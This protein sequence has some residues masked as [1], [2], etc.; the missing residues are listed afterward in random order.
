MGERKYILHKIYKFINLKSEYNI[1]KLHAMHIL[2]LKTCVEKTIMIGLTKYVCWANFA[3]SKQNFW[4][5]QLNILVFNQNT[6]LILISAAYI[7]IIS[8]YLVIII[9]KEK[10][11]IVD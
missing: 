5:L 3:R 1:S 11:S 9:T 2:N 7:I 8:K 6:V 10:K 4:L